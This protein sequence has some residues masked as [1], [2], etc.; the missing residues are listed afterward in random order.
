MGTVVLPELP[1]CDV[2]QHFGYIPPQKATA[3]SATLLGPWGY[4]CETHKDYR[5]G[6]VTDLTTQ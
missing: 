5:V 3:D 4:T 2:C 6:A 1:N